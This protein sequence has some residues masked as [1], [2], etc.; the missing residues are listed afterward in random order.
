[1]KDRRAPVQLVG[2]AIR[3]R[4]LQVGWSQRHLADQTGTS[5]S[6]VSRIERGEV[7]GLSI[8]TASRLF[9]AMGARLEIGVEGPILASGPR[10]K[11]PAHARL[12]GYVVR[13][14]RSA[15]WRTATEVEVGGDRSRGWIDVLAFHQESGV[16]LL[17]EL[18]TEIHDLGAIERTLNWYRREAWAAARRLGWRPRRVSSWL[19]LLATE[20]NDSRVIANRV[21]IDAGFPRRSRHFLEIIS[22]TGGVDDARGIAMV[23]PRSRRRTWFRPLRIDGR[24]RGAS[25]YRDYADFMRAVATRPGTA[26]RQVAPR[27]AC[28]TSRPPLA[29]SPDSRRFPSGA[30]NS[31]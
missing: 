19:L 31:A 23:D 24:S 3:T 17:I 5:R 13:R 14:L 11:D 9:E 25:P 12:S 16:V 1:M 30:P 21:S 20:A 8:L 18:K 15:G 22:G 10:Q 27:A 6:V 29:A 7:P 28:D 2:L 4:R 26:R